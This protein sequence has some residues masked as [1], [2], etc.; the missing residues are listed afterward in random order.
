MLKYVPASVQQGLML[1]PILSLQ[2]VDVSQ[3]TEALKAATQV[4]AITPP[5]PQAS[6]ISSATVPA[7]P[8]TVT[9]PSSQASPSKAMTKPSTS[10]LKPSAQ[11]R[12]FQGFHT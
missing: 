2:P 1:A 6:K 5:K 10:T 3:A 12:P 4:V 11:S 7:K 9:P 8:L